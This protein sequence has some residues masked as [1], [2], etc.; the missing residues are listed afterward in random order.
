MGKVVKLILLLV[1]VV[2]AIRGYQYLEDR[3]ITEESSSEEELGTVDLL[4]GRGHV[5]R[6]LEIKEKRPEFNLPALKTAMSQFRVDKGRYPR[7]LEELEV[8]N[9]AG[10]DV[11]CDP[12]GQAYRLQ[13]QGKAAIL[14]S[15]G[16]DKQAGTE[17]DIRLTL[18]LP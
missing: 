8:A 11:T 5:R 7:N 18:Q 1:V 9:L 14:T 16:K 15:P 13:Y 12:F 3:Q 4:V 10:R 6:Y 17:D 2:V